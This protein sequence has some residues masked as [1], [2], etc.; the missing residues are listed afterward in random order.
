MRLAF[1]ASILLAVSSAAQDP[2]QTFQS[3]Q[4]Y[5]DFLQK[6]PGQW[7]AQWH[8][9]T[10][11]P[12]AIYGTG[13]PLANWR[14]N[15]LG[16]AREHA[17]QVLA[18]YRDLLGLGTSEWR[19]SIGSRMGRTWSFKFDQYFGGLPVIGGRADV[20]INMVGTLAMMGSVAF[21]VP[22]GFNTV[23]VVAEGLATAIAWQEVGTPTGVPQPGPQRPAQLVI[24]GDSSAQENAPFFLAWEVPVSNVDRNGEGPIGR[25]YI[26]AVAG[27]VLHYRTDKHECGNALCGNSH[28]GIERAL[29]LTATA[30][31]PAPVPTTVTVMAWTRTGD[32]A[33]SALVNT[34]LQGIVLNVPGVGT[35]TTDQNGQFSIDIAAPV[36]ITASALDGTHHAAITGA[37]APAISQVVNPGV[38][39]TIQIGTA[40]STPNEAAHPT[41]SYWVDR[42]NEWLRSI[43]DMNVA[44]NQTAMNGA[45]AVSP[46]V[47]ITSTCNAYY[48]GNTIN[49][50]SA[51]GGCSN[52]AFSTVVVHEWGHGLDDRFG[53]ISNSTGDGLSEGWGDIVGMY[54]VDSPILG[55]GFQ[56]AGVGIRNGMNTKMYG[57]QSEVHAAGEIWMG[58]AW[59]Y[60]QNLRATLGTAAAIAISDDTVVGSIIADATNQA[61]AVREVFIADDNDGNL[62]NGTPHYN[63]LSAAAIAKGIPYPQLMLAYITHAPLPN[64]DTRVT[65]RKVSCTAGVVSSGAI[66]SVTLHYSAA[67]GPAQVRNMHPNGSTDGYEAMLPGLSSG[68]VNYHIEAVHNG[69]TTVRSPASGEHSYVV[70][71]ASGGAFTS[72]WSDNFDGP[73]LGWTHAMVATQDDW[74]QGTPAGR[75]GTSQ[76]VAWAD[77]AAAASG[78]NCWGND[79]GGTGFNGA[80]QNNVNNYLRS[81]IINCSG[82]SGVAIRFKRWLTVEEGIY[83]LATLSVNGI[84]VWQ[85]QQNGHTI[86]TA[87]Q[88]VQYSLPMADNNPSV[89]IEFRLQT[90]A[91]LTLGGWNID[92]VQLGELYVPPLDATFTMLPEQAVQ[93]SPINLS[94]QTQGGPKPVLVVI[95]GNGG[96]TNFPGVPPILVGGTFAQIPFWTNASG[97]FGISFNAPAVPSTIGSTWYSQALTLDA[98]NTQI[99]TSNQFVNLFTQTP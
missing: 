79:L 98:T 74:Q 32:D 16:H 72:F 64:T 77:P 25:Y 81:P 35:R 88:Q 87:W 5:K 51:G 68:L 14:E 60:R 18:D 86:D 1:C 22:A 63:E 38:A 41:T 40:A 78:A 93:G 12:R 11:T 67:G 24:W 3:K 30:P 21:P 96:P 95:G 17:N 47:N 57:T 55:S 62:A 50:Y 58:F 89:Q 34:P 43:L 4:A 92:D 10:Q 33:Y 65:P 48:T 28:H 29:A 27:N 52:T 97:T 7:V 66:T 42:A 6:T 44:S 73:A 69:T 76:G 61:D 80:Y 13:L 2:G 15:T 26:D 45:S 20:R 39:T 83:D 46:R 75:S 19:E 36:T 23:P 94:V 84:Q 37:N 85:N 99:V 70:D 71:A 82:R 56:T 90:D 8:P 91:G 53:G 9:A 49:F 31:L 59:R 54:L